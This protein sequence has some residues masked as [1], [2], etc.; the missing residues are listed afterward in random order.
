MTVVTDT[1][2]M[3]DPG[4]DPVGAK[5]YVRWSPTVPGVLPTGTVLPLPF[6]VALVNG[7]M[8]VD[9]A[10]TGPGWVW[11]VTY[12]FYGLRQVTKYYLVPNVP[13][14]LSIRDLTEVDPYTSDPSIEPDQGWYAYLGLLAEKQVGV[15]HVVTGDEPREDFGSVI[16]IGGA[17][18]PVNMAELTDIWFK[19]AS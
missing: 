18:Q 19:P 11:A 15:V 13:G 3:P 12:Q 7:T 14:P 5:G 17:T 16:W 10:A 9:I 1:F 6:R 4:P 8:T 2:Y